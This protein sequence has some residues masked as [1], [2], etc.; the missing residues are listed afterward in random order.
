MKK[1]TALMF[2]HRNRTKPGHAGPVEI[3]VTHER[4]S[5]YF[6]TG[7]KVLRDEFVAGRV[8]NTL[9]ADKLNERIAIIYEKVLSLINESIDTG[10]AIDT[11]MIK[12]QVWQIKEKV[13]DGNT[14]LDWIHEQIPLLDIK[15]DTRKHYYPLEDRLREFGKMR[16]WEDVTV[17]RI[18]EFDAW[19]H[20][21]QKPISDAARLA[22]VK[23]K[24]LSDAGIYNYH[25]CLKALLNRAD[26]FGKIE[27]NPY[28]R[29]RGQ[30]KRGDKDNPE[31]LTDDEMSRIR[32]LE[33][34]VG[35]ALD[36]ARDLFVF[37]MYTGLAYSDAQAFDFSAYKM[38]SGSWQYIGQRVKTGVPYVS[39]LL[40]PAVEV[41]EKYRGTV[42]K[43]GNADYN[44]R[45]KEIGRLTGIE[46]RMHSHLARH[47][48]ATWMLAND[49]KIENVKQ[50]LGHKSIVTTQRYAKVIATSVYEDFGKV[51]KKI[52]P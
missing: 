4:R 14:L 10:K 8:V 23:P 52:K 40:P 13:R 33:L 28:E 1:T 12:R 19:L 30:F 20:S 49:V 6:D 46:V 16:R 15:D 43:I 34:P 7:V 21:R 9:C 42:P 47:T 18:C 44:H 2:D 31:Y 35:S 38:V 3:R 5:Y 24:R 39:E 51:R 22:G 25:K 26:R 17:E 27:R 41:L 36:V 45:L 48:F 50:M 29:L 37:Q 11:E 32:K